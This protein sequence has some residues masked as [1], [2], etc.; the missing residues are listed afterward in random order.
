[1]FNGRRPAYF[2]SLVV[3]TQDSHPYRR[4]EMRAALYSRNLVLIVSFCDRALKMFLSLLNATHASAILEFT[5][6]SVELRYLNAFAIS[7][8]WLSIMMFA[9][10]SLSFR[11]IC[12]VFF[13]LISKPVMAATRLSSFIGFCWFVLLFSNSAMSSAN[14]KSCTRRSFGLCNCVD[15]RVSS[16]FVLNCHHCM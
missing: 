15:F 12:T 13:T 3:S 4:M 10:L 11:R 8:G 2:L 7:T 6:F 5:S 1:M 9:S 16:N 14:V